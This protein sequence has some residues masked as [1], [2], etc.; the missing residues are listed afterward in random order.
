MQVIEITVIG[1]DFKMNGYIKNLM[2]ANESKIKNLFLQNPE[3][4]YNLSDIKKETKLNSKTVKKRVMAL[5]ESGFLIQVDN[6]PTLKSYKLKMVG[7]LNNA[8]KQ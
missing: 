1:A 8:D 2:K 5:V 3:R 6:K 7:G 4:Q